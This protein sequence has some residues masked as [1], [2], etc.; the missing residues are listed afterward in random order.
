MSQHS[1]AHRR[2]LDS[3]DRKAPLDQAECTVMTTSG[4]LAISMTAE[5]I[6]SSIIHVLGHSWQNVNGLS[7]GRLAQWV[8]VEKWSKATTSPLRVMHGTSSQ[9]PNPTHLLNL[10]S[11]AAS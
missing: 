7:N 11:R 4:P 3:V 1:L 10:T 8:D 6:D 9:R 5:D 2:R